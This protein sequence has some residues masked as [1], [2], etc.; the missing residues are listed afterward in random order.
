MGKND[1]CISGVL[2]GSGEEGGK[3]V[4]VLP[5]T[6]KGATSRARQPT[7][8]SMPP[9]WSMPD[10]FRCCPDFCWPKLPNVAAI[11]TSF[12]H[13][14]PRSS[15]PPTPPAAPRQRHQ[16][17]TVLSSPTSVAMGFWDTITDLVEAATPWATADAEAPAAESTVR[18]SLFCG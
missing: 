8:Q 18:F 11:G 7:G 13:H 12:H 1:Y 17:T 15:Q 3:G 10:D 14:H 4:R 5:L 6:L 9:N 2:L 16:L